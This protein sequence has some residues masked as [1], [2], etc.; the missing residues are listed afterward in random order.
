M[1]LTELPIWLRIKQC[2]PYKSK[3]KIPQNFLRIVKA[4][5]ARLLAS[6]PGPDTCRVGDTRISRLALTDFPA[7]CPTHLNASYTRARWVPRAQ[8][9]LESEREFRRSQHDKVFAKKYRAKI[10]RAVQRTKIERHLIDVSREIGR[11]YGERVDS[12]LW[13]SSY[14]GV[15]WSKSRTHVVDWNFYRGRCKFPL[16]YYNAGVWG[17][18]VGSNWVITLTSV[19]NKKITLPPIPMKHMMQINPEVPYA[20]GLYAL[21]VREGSEVLV[22][23]G[24]IGSRWVELIEYS[25]RGYRVPPCMA[26]GNIT[27][28]DIEREPNTEVKRILI[29]HFGFEKYL[30][31]SSAKAIHQDAYGIL[32]DIPGPHRVVRVINSTPN[33]DGSANQYFIPV[34][35]NMETA[36]QAV[37]WTFN[38]TPERY[39]P[40]TQS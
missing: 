6:M 32:Y 16:S 36:H 9:F 25:Y 13:L 22:C 4:N 5:P 40:H 37:A 27:Y 28:D 30:D 29:E 39:K 23:Y 33:P 21:P 12:T 38:L 34:P 3:A 1:K 19:R 24:F 35:H 26:T 11:A 15:V 2:L 10:R 20:A 7:I 31:A 17:E 8:R 14:G 18:R